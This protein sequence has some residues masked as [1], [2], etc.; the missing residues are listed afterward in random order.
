[1][2]HKNLQKLSMQILSF[3]MILIMAGT[4]T[5]QC[6]S[7]QMQSTAYFTGECGSHIFQ[8]STG[9]TNSSF[10][11]CGNLYFTPPI[12]EG[13]LSTGVDKEITGDVIIRPNPA[14][15][16]LEIVFDS[17]LTLTGISIFNT[18]GQIVLC[19]ESSHVQNFID[20]QS[21]LPGIYFIRISLNGLKP[22]VRKFVKI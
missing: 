4:I 16:R 14:S 20:L 17:R 11:S 13:D 7:S 19:T 22:V 3:S 10:G 12:T 6:L 18:T 15:E 9:S 2:K 1:M 5:G 8:S 21:I